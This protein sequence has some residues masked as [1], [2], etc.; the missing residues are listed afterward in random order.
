ME[1]IFKI[2]EWARALTRREWP[3]VFSI[4][5]ETTLRQLQEISLDDIDVWNQL[6]DEL[7]KSEDPRYEGPSLNDEIGPLGKHGLH[8]HYHLSPGRGG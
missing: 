4:R 5:E 3:V 6:V 8:Y 7:A 2:A 1:H